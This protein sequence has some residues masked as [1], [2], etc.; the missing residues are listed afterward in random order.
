MILNYGE[1]LE[2]DHFQTQFTEAVNMIFYVILL[3][4]V[5]AFALYGIN[6]HALIAEQEARIN[7]NQLM[8][9]FGE[10]E[11]YSLDEIKGDQLELPDRMTRRETRRRTT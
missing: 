8:R 2:I 5:F 10:E 4:F 9:Y 3:V 11:M 6:Q 1:G 7:M